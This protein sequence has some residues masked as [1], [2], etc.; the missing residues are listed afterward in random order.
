MVR[1]A[2]NRQHNVLRARFAGLFSSQTLEELDRLVVAFTMRRGPAHGLLDFRA[3][4]AVVVPTG[5]LLRRSQQPPSNPGHK[6][7][8]VA[9]GQQALELARTFAHEQAAL[10]L[11]H[12]QI[13]ATLEEAYA[14]LALS[15]P[16]PRF[17]PVAGPIGG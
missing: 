6:R 13:V 2:Y 10:G 5:I 11:G 8:F 17:E 12:V 9:P 4:E 7:V 14:L 1:L 3:V 15:G 16:F